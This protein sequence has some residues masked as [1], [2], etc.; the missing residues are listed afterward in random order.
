MINGTLRSGIALT[1]RNTFAMLEFCLV[2]F[3]VSSSSFW[4]CYILMTLPSLC[5]PLMALAES[6]RVHYFIGVRDGEVRDTLVV[7]LRSI[8]EPLALCRFNISCVSAIVLRR[9]CDI[10]SINIMIR[11]HTLLVRLPVDLNNTVHR[12]K[13]HLIAVKWPAEMSIGQNIGRCI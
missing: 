9:C 12:S 6:F 2:A 13:R 10:T 8:R 5:N 3:R 4:S 11:S 7:E 1:C